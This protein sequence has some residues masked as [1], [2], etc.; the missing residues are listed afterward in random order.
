MEEKK[1]KAL[2]VARE[3]FHK[4]GYR[5][6]SLSDLIEEIGISKPTFYNYFKNKEELFYAVMLATYN[7]F[8]YQYS[9]Q[10][11]SAMNALEKLQ[12]FIETFAWF[13][14]K[15]PLY[16]DLYK[17][18]NDLMAK[19]VQSRYSKDFFSEGV[20]TIAS[21]LEEGVQ[22]GIFSHGIDTGKFSL[23][24]Y[25]LVLAVLSTDPGLYRKANQPEYKIDV[26]SL[27]K[28]IGHGLLARDG[29]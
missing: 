1:E 21:I 28:M 20:D 29:E 22:E 11:K 8:H 25:Y 4:F 26:P 2:E 19:W 6:A 10:E 27:I 17:P 18:G 3:Y 15:F 16:Q 7:E 13:I 5:K 23:L 24:I 12:A 9:Q 14:N